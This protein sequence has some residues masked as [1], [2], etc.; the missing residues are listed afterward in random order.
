MW[1]KTNLGVRMRL[2]GNKVVMWREGRLMGGDQ[3]YQQNHAAYLR[4][5]E[6]I[7]QSYPSGWFVGIAGGHIVGAA[8]NFRELE[9]LLR[10]KGNDPRTVLVVEAGV[11]YPEYGTIFHR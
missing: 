5:K 6:S 2:E 7:K 9:C 8:K 3:D 11:T 4:L 1:Q 10:A